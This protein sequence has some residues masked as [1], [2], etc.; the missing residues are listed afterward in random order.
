MSVTFEDLI[1]SG[2]FALRSAAKFEF[3][4]GTYGIWNG[5]GTINILGIDYISNLLASFDDAPYAL[6]T[7]AIPL[8][9]TMVESADD[10]ITPNSLAQIEDEDYKNRPVTIYD[11]YFDPDTSE[12]I[13]VEPLRTGYVDF[14]DHVFE[15]GL[16]S[17]VGHLETRA[18]DNFRDGYRSASNA[19]QQLISPGDRGLEYASIVKKESFDISFDD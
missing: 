9:I 6:G 2:N 1:E 15:N 14:I 16:A 8:T 19:D 18:I 5:L 3:G 7:Q 11:L 10:G 4:T 12:L 17:I 13:H